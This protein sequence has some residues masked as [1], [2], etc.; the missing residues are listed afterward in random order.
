MLYLIFK[1]NIRIIILERKKNNDN[2]ST[3]YFKSLN[4]ILTNKKDSR[5]F[6]DNINIIN[7]PKK[8]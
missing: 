8:L 1:Q 5:F 6:T 2:L 3:Q 7:I 4:I